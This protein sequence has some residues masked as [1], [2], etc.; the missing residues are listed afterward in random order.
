MPR[1]G[2]DRMTPTR[3]QRGNRGSG[4]RRGGG[5]GRGS[6]SAPRRNAGSAAG[7]GAVPGHGRRVAE[8]CALAPFSVFCAL[9]LGITEDDGFARP[10]AARVA[11]RFDLSPE[12][13]DQY[14]SDHGLTAEDLKAADFDLE[15][16]RLDIQVAPEGISRVE[17]ARTMFEEVHGNRP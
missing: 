17:L 3:R 13:L 16:A 8:L 9:Y 14:L 11:R 6:S 15:G 12:Q 10:E 4:R 5:S 2:V 7:N 1:G